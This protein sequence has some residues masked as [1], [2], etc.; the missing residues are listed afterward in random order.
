M[1]TKSNKREG[2]I[3]MRHGNL[4]RQQ[5]IEIA[6]EEIVNKLDYVNCEPTSRLQTDGD[7]STEYSASI[8]FDSKDDTYT[9]TLIA[10]YYTTPEQ[11]TKL[12]ENDGDGSCI[13]WEINGYEIQ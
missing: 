1:D 5:A 6:G 4:T 12:A 7:D 3:K 2:I 8:R 13:N 9:K 10:Y 11:E